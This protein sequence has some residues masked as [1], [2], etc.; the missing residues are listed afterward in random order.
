MKIQ[1][2]ILAIGLFFAT[3]VAAQERAPLERTDPLVKALLEHSSRTNSLK[4]DFSQA[5]HL[6]M[7]AT[8][9]ISGGIIR[10]A[11]PGKLRW[12]VDTP[13]A[14]VAVVDGKTVKIS[15]KGKEQPVT[16][17]DR[18]TY[19]AIS[20][21]IEG[22]V[23]GKLMNGQNMKTQFFKTTKGVLIELVP[24][25]PKMA[26]HL[27]QVQLT[28]NTADHTLREMRMQQPNGDF[29]LTTFTKASFG[30]DHP[31]GAFNLP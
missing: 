14:S 6:K 4:A 17:V 20:D 5:K 12:Q 22:I 10:F 23:S 28:F 31:V 1:P 15:Q 8:P 30:V 9:V 19:G 29:T 25:D 21:L 26:K 2:I 13:E 27:A 18:Q 3:G 16:A 7:L 11:K 24:N